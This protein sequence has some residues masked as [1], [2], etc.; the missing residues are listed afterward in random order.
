MEGSG[1]FLTQVLYSYFAA[2]TE[3]IYENLRIFNVPGEI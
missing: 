3:E 2:G 1:I